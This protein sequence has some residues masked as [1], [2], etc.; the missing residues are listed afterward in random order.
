MKNHSEIGWV[1]REYNSLAENAQVLGVRSPES[2]Y[3]DGKMDG[4]KNKDKE[5]EAKVVG[6]SI[7]IFNRS[8]FIEA[9]ESNEDIH[10]NKKPCLT[11]LPGF[12]KKPKSL[13]MPRF[14]KGFMLSRLSYFK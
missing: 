11:K 14:L 10:P 9:F 1:L 12:V 7:D 2:H 6:K 5:N 8:S 13:R 4:K 3:I